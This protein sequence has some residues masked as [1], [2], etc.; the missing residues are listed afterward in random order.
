LIKCPNC[1][2]QNQDH[3]KFCLGCG[4]ELPRDAVRA[5]AVTSSPTPPSGIPIAD[6]QP[7]V[8]PQVVGFKVEPKVEPKKTPQVP[9]KPFQVEV[10]PPTPPPGKVPSKQVVSPQSPA[11]PSAVE[12]ETRKFQKCPTCGADVPPDFAFCG[13]CG[14]RLSS[15]PPAPVKEVAPSPPKA[16][17]QIL[18]KIVMIQPTG[19]EGISVPVT[20]RGAE[21]GRA[22]GEAFREDYFLSPKHSKFVVEGSRLFVEDLGSLNGI[23]I[24]L[25]PEV[26]YEI[27]DGDFIRIG[28]EV[29]KFE[30]LPEPPK[31]ETAVLGSPRKDAWGR[32]ALVLGKNRIGNAF[33][34]TGKE[35]LIGRERGNVIFPDDG[36]V[37]GLHLKISKE[38][39]KITVTDLKS[40]NGSYLRI[41][42]RREVKNGDYLLIGQFLYRV[43]FG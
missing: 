14:S 20:Q 38:N 5:S 40:S 24:R 11:V 19:V 39:G 7:V 8:V 42:G 12:T 31:Q 23:Y 41:R 29:I 6:Q 15:V 4:S 22:S 34:I 30:L 16:E 1:G 10:K 3:Y 25:A 2:K 26:P 17:A 35:V 21:I 43:D 9:D 33:T 37:S 36:Y 13:R 28:Q 27:A 18:G 32:I